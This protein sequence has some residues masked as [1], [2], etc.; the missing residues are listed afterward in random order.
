MT[1]KESCG[2]LSGLA[3]KGTLQKDTKGCRH[4]CFLL[5]SAKEESRSYGAPSDVQYIRRL[6]TFLVAQC[7]KGIAADQNVA[8]VVPRVLSKIP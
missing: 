7:C 2:V 4:C 3:T 5:L 8:K 6:P 1:N